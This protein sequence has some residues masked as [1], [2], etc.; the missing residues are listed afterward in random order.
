MQR[1]ERVVFLAFGALFG[2]ITFVAPIYPVSLIIVIW[3]IAVSANY[4]AIQRLYYVWKESL[5][6]NSII[7]EEE[8]ENDREEDLQKQDI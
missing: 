6:L 7:E 4:T 2:D 8:K 3:I 1:Q 5:K